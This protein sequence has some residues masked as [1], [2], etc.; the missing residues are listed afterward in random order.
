MEISWF[1]IPDATRKVTEHSDVYPKKAGVSCKT[2][3]QMYLF[4]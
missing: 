1:G 2:G 4:Y 3:T